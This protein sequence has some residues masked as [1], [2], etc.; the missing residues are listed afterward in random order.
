MAVRNC[1]WLEFFN[2]LLAPGQYTI[3]SVPHWIPASPDQQMGVWNQLSGSPYVAGQYEG[4]Q[5]GYLTTGM[6][7]KRPPATVKGQSDWVL[8]WRAG[9]RPGFTGGLRVR[10]Y[11]GNQLLA[12]HVES[13]ATI[14]A[15]GMFAERSLPFTIPAG[16]PAIGYQV[17]FTIEVGFGFQANFDDFRRESTDPGPG[18]TADL[19]F[20]NAVTDEDFQF[21]VERYNELIAR[22]DGG[23]DLNFD[24]LVDDSDFQ[25]FVVQYNTLEC[26]E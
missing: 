4:A 25:L 11:A 5:I 12:E 9:N 24:F 17:R 23:G 2:S 21:F 7:E 22:P 26:P 10:F 20:D 19:N 6:L 14:P 18:C 8:R 3:N 16:S 1:D 15:A 13:G